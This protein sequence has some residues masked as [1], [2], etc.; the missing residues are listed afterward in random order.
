MSRLKTLRGCA[1]CSYFKH[2]VIRQHRENY[3]TET[4]ANKDI[5][6][7]NI[8]VSRIDKNR[9]K[10]PTILFNDFCLCPLVT[11]YLSV[12]SVQWQST[13]FIINHAVM[14]TKEELLWV[15]IPLF[16]WGVSQLLYWIIENIHPLR[17][18]ETYQRM[19]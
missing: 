16:I 10:V 12:I 7:A 6:D 19:R 8:L 5:I 9:W 3:P 17:R 14:R 15:N 13:N 18:Q 4:Y 2:C 1:V 11:I